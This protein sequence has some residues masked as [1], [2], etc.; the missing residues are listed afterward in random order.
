MRHPGHTKTDALRGYVT[1]I[2][3]DRCKAKPFKPCV[4][5]TGRPRT[6]HNARM[7]STWTAAALAWMDCCCCGG[8]DPVNFIVQCRGKNLH[9][10][11]EGCW[12]AFRRETNH[13]KLRFCPLQPEMASDADA[14]LLVLR[15]ESA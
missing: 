9:I 7:F 5:R 14:A 3:C 4:T 2:D 1:G 10:V 13:G 11:C 12:K 15:R 8:S 6:W